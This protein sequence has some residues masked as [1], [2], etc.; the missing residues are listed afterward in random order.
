MNH[1]EDGFAFLRQ[2]GGK[3]KRPKRV[4]VEVHRTENFLELGHLVTVKKRN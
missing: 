3:L 1:I 2:F 4:R